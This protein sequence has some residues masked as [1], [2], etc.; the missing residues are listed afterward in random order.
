MTGPRP[1]ARLALFRPIEPGPLRRAPRG[2]M[3]EGPERI[4]VVVAE[5]YDLLAK[6]IAGRIAEIISERAREGRHAVLGLATGST[7]IG[8]YRELIRMHRDEGLDLEHVV[9]FNLDEYYPMHPDNRHSYHRFMRENF[10]DHV[11]IAPANVHLPRGDVPREAVAD[12]CRRYEQAI[13]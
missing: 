1:Y 2:A 7:P 11:N 13:R 10:F 3:R 4:P 5:S 9:T 8:I 12:E 6:R